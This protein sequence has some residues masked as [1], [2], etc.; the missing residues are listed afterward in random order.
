M[1]E[2]QATGTI[3]IEHIAEDSY[4]VCL[5]YRYGVDEPKMTWDDW[6]NAWGVVVGTYEYEDA[7]GLTVTCPKIE[8]IYWD[9]VLY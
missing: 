7:D 3:A 2:Q 5:V 9:N 6:I 4:P 1:S 8:V